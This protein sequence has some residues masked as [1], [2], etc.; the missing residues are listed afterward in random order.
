MTSLV[1]FTSAPANLGDSEELLCAVGWLTYGTVARLQL[2]R[3]RQQEQI[4]SETPGER[5]ARLQHLSRSRLPLR[6]GEREARL[7]HLRSHQQEQI[8]SE[9][10][11]ERA[12]RLQH[13]R[14][15][16]QEQI[17]SETPGERAACLQLL[18]ALQQEQITPQETAARRQRDREAHSHRPPPASAQPL[19]HQ[20]AVQARMKKLPSLKRALPP[21]IA[22]HSTLPQGK[23][24]W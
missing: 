20:P 23:S 24:T 10:P 15:R 1:T 11:G 21:V 6:P 12:A 5:A 19:L 7:Q 16:Q 8:A 14:A 9:T 3:V 17:A 18:R 2:L 13:L 22:A 4:A